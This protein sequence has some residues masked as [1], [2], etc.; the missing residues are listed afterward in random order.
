MEI[1]FPT[2][3]PM[4][5]RT[6]TATRINLVKPSIPQTPARIMDLTFL[7]LGVTLNLFIILV[8]S[9]KASMRTATNYYLVSLACSNMVILV[10]PLQ[11]IL[12][13]LFLVDKKMNMDY[14]CLISFDVSVITIAVLKFQLYI[15]VFRQHTFLGK[16][17]EKKHVAIKG[18]SLIWSASIISVAIGLHIYDFYEGD[19]A[20]IYVWNTFLF[21]ILPFLI[22]VALDC[23]IL[24][25]LI[26]FKEIDGSWRLKELQHCIMLMV[27]TMA[28]FLIRTPYRVARAINFI[29]PKMWCCTDS[30]REI[31]F[32]IAKSFPAVFSIIYMA[33]SSEFHSAFKK[34]ET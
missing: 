32:F 22:F 23:L 29:W 19:M 4:P 16:Q 20:D 34:T 17:L 30:K 10:E 24:Y 7:S 11:E 12:R 27:I 14:V 8:I 3:T 25:N 9:S 6:T 18:I 1:W 13:W 5:S 21:I 33:S 15:N 2:M 31:L 26:I 28:F